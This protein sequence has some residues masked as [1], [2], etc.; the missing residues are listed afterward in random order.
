MGEGANSV[1]LDSDFQ[2]PGNEAPTE[3]EF[4]GALK[5]QIAAGPRRLVFDELALGRRNAKRAGSVTVALQSAVFSQ[6]ADGGTARIEISIVY[7][8]G[9]PA[10]ESYRTWMYHNEA[11]LESKAGR[12]IAPGPFIEAR[13][14]GDGSI[15]FEYNFAHVDGNPSDYQFVSIV[16]TLIAELPV[17]F[18]FAK[19]PVTKTFGEGT[20]R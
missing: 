15:L 20:R 12:R 3:I 5:V 8:Q 10:F 16:P 13:Q 17:Q 2:F 9:G 11:A 7:D 4:R 19:I 14:Q 6:G 18:R 1:H